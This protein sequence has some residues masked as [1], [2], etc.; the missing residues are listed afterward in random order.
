MPVSN[1]RRLALALAAALGLHVL[2]FA[3]L[4]HGTAPPAEDTRRARVVTV[5]LQARALPAPRRTPAPTPTPQPP[6]PPTPPVHATFAPYNATRAAAAKARAAHPRRSGGA[7]APN[8]LAVLAPRPLQVSRADSPAHAADAGQGAAAGSGTGSDAGSAEAG[9]NATGF[10]SGKVPGNGTA[11]A[12]TSPCAD[13]YLLPGTLSYRK[14]GTVVQQ[15]LAKIV[16]RDGTVEVD[17]FPYPFTYAA[18]KL[19]PFRHD[20]EVDSPNGGIP[21]QQPPRGMDVTA[22]P[23]SVQTILKYTDPATGY[24]SLPACP[25]SS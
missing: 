25:R 4:P 9:G 7:A 23:A 5:S 24:T 22:M 3:L 6:T 18:E 20:E 1:R 16:A 14:D 13:I 12:A 10:G 21:V 19:N 8:V 17:R 11:D 2:A 15:V